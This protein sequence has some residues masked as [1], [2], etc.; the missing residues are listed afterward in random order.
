MLWLL[1]TYKVPPEPTARRVAIWRKL[2]RLGA[3]LLHDS[4][5][6]LPNTPTTH[7]QLQW[8][9]AEIHEMEGSAMLWQ[10]EQ[11]LRGQNNTLIQQ[12]TEQ[13]DSL[14]REILH[15]LEQ[16]NADLAALSRRYQQIKAQDYF[17]S[18]LGQQVRDALLRL[19]GG[20]S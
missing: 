5:W 7:E 17:E 6:I 3:I 13:V 4:V 1:L 14:Y 8:I 15:D 18:A 20:N 9:V 11:A 16:E 2:K 19:R 10:A 12:F